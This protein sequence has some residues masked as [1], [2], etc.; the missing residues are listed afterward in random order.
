MNLTQN[1]NINNITGLSTHVTQV[2]KNFFLSF[3]YKQYFEVYIVDEI[4]PVQIWKDD[5]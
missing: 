5:T 1:Q 2:F 3:L 4:D